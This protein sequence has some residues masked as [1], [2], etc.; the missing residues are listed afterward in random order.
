MSKA[1]NTADMAVFGFFNEVGIINQLSTTLLA[2]CLPD[3]VH[4]SHFAII[5]HLVRMGDEKSP[6]RI[7]AAMQVTKNTMTH[8]LKVLSE[9]GFIEVGPD[10]EDGRGK[11]VKLTYAG[12]AF[13]E[14]A[15]KR[16]TDRFSVIV[17]PEH[18]DIMQKTL[19]DLVVIRRLLDENR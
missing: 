6:V 8:S 13:R 3:G 18:R 15:I 4:P 14:D 7:A 2:T 9:R 1:H 11:I 16:V 5:N 17:Q 10:P 19:G 12:R